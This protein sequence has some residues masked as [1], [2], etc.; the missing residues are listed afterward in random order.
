M[1]PFDEMNDSEVETYPA[2]ESIDF[3]LKGTSLVSHKLH[4]FA[5]P[6]LLLGREVLR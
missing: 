3:T 1:C 5:D 2:S 6:L 4:D